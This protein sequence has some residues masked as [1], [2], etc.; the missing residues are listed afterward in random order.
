M[1]SLDQSDCNQENTRLHI[2]DHLCSQGLFILLIVMYNIPVI[3]VVQNSYFQCCTKFLFLV[4]YS[5]PV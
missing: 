4:M 5:I 1:C 2:Y 3:C